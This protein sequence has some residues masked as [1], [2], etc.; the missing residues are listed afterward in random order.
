MWKSMLCGASAGLVAQFAASPTD[1]V[2]VSTVGW[3]FT[4]LAP[5][6]RMNGHIT[7]NGSFRLILF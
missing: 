4:S 5:F 2:K 7:P 3:V 1:L 6:G